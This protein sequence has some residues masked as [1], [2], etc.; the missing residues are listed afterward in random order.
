MDAMHTTPNDILRNPLF[1]FV[2]VLGVA[3]LAVATFLLL[4]NFRA[5]ALDNPSTL[6]A[7]TDPVTGALTEQLRSPDA[8]S[9]AEAAQALVG[10][11]DRTARTALLANLGDEDPTAGY[12]TALALSQNQDQ[13]TVDALLAALTHEDLLVRQRAGLALSN[14]GSLPAQAAPTL[15]AALQDEGTATF[16]AEALTHVP[17]PAAQDALLQALAD[18]ELTARRHA[19]MAAIEQAD[20]TYAKALLARALAS[21]NPTLVRNATTLQEFM[22]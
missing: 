6:A 16:A 15:A 1:R 19:A 17:G 21:D 12:H 18:D 10:T 2:A 5:A 9:R 13:A 3:L 11:T 7:P 4:S 20:A 14:M 8:Q 22:Q